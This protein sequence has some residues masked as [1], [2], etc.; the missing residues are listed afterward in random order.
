MTI[1]L[2]GTVLRTLATY[3]AGISTVILAVGPRRRVR[4]QTDSAVAAQLKDGQQIKV[5]IETE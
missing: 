4:F 2:R 3:Q 5:T 1:Q